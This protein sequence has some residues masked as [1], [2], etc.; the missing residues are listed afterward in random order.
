MNVVARRALGLSQMGVVRIGSH[1]FCLLRKLLVGP[2]TTYADIH[3]RRLRRLS[4][5]VA[6]L[7]FDTC[8]GV[9]VEQK[10]RRGLNIRI[11]AKEQWNHHN[12]QP[13]NGTRQ[14]T[15]PLSFI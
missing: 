5:A 7:A 13:S 6:G 1:L 12:K 4:G 9:L 8:L 3:A 10:R 15:Q 11:G 14:R 2:V